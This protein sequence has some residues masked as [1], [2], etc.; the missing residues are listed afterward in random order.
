MDLD[1]YTV[2][3]DDK[4][5]KGQ[6]RILYNSCMADLYAM[7][8]QTGRRL[9]PVAV[10]VSDRE[11]DRFTS[12]YSSHFFPTKS[13]HLFVLHKACDVVIIVLLM[14]VG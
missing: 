8:V 11:E 6:L 10:P 14:H 4:Y 12:R 13:D 3:K 5:S 7:M 1:F 9:L 2:G